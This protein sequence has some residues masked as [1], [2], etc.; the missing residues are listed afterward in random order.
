M[1]IEKLIKQGDKLR[2][3]IKEKWNNIGTV[4]TPAGYYIVDNQSYLE[5]KTSSLMFL[6]RNYGSDSFVREFEDIV[7]KGNLCPENHDKMIAILKAIQNNSSPTENI[8][9][10]IN[11]INH[12]EDLQRD[13]N[14]KS[15]TK[16]ANSYIVINAFHEWYSTSFSFL[17]RYYTD[18]DSNFRKFK[19]VRLDANGYTLRDEY[20]SIKPSYNVLLDSLKRNKS[21]IMTDT[22]IAKKNYG[23]KV[24]IV[25]GHNVSVKLTVARILEKLG[26]EAVILHEQP[27]GGKTIIEKLE[28][29]TNE[30]GFAV[31]LLTADD[32]GKALG[33]TNL[34]KRAR[35]NVVFEMGL[36]MGILGRDRVMLLLE[37]GVEKPGDLDG[38][39]YTSI[40]KNDGWKYALCDE[41]KRVGYQ[42]S[43][44]KL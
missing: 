8:S 9:D 6:R 21:I 10:I 38:I 30:I 19:A 27:N 2:N 13:Y 34:N 43:K 11:E 26:L 42:V 39:V 22:I 36:F 24:F 28:N 1:T 25:H 14:E 33:E 32:E 16:D 3:E 18:D 40:D 12:L 5:W 23:N 31:I 15:E 29:N 41:L 35:Q 17:N 7:N 4:F 20:Y 37:D 44:D